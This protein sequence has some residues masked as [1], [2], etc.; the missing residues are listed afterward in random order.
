VAKRKPT[1][2]KALPAGLA[3]HSEIIQGIEVVDA[4]ERREHHTKDLVGMVA[5]AVGLLAVVALATYAQGTTAGITRDVIAMTS[6]VTAIFKATNNALMNAAT[7]LA[8]A[9]VLATLLF[10]RQFWPALQGSLAGIVSFGLAFLTA[11]GVRALDY[12]PMVTGLSAGP[13]G[14]YQVAIAPLAAAMAGILTAVGPRS[15]RPILRFSWNLLWLALAVWVLT[16][17]GTMGS[18]MVTVLLGRI[19][20][21]A[22]RYL[23]GVST[24]RA[25]GRGLI[26]GIR[27]A[28]IE[29]VRVVRVRDISDPE[30]PTDRL[31]VAAIRHGASTLEE[32]DDGAPAPPTTE[33]PEVGELS[34]VSDST[35]LALERQAGNRVYAVYT[36]EGRRWDALVLDGDQQVLGL[37]QRTW[38]A[39]RL[40]G[41]DQRSVVSLRQAA[42]RAALLSYTAASAGVRTPSLRGIGEASDSMMLLQS[43]PPGLRSIRDMRAREVQDQALVEM[44]R[45]LQLAH[46]AGLAHRSV[47]Q[48]C[49]LFG[50]GPDGQQVPWLTGWDNGDVASSELAR[51]LDRAQLATMLALRLGPDR[52]V[53][54]AAQVLDAESLA[55]VASLIQ[56]VALPSQTREEARGRAE[57]LDALRQELLD[58]SPGEPLER[59]P[60][61]VRLGWSKVVLL[62]LALV[63]VIVVLTTQ[64][65]TQMV[66]AVADTNPWWLVLAFGL[67]LATYVGAA[68]TL[69][70]FHRD[71]VS[72]WKA[73]LAQVAASFWAL[74]APGG[75]GP[76]AT[77]LRFLS[78][79]GS[80]ASLAI[81][82]V[83]LTQ[84]ALVFTTLL[85]LLG[86]GFTSG[87]TGVLS[88]LPGK[89]II[90]VVGALV[91]LASLLLIPRLRGW[92]WLK[93]GPTFAQVWPALTWVLSKPKRIILAMVGTVIQT[94]GYIA[95]F[96]AVLQAFDLGHL[97]LLNLALVFLLG[98]SAGSA[99]P[100]PGGVGGVEI[101]LAASLVAAGVGGATIAFSVALVF[102][103]I[104]YW[105]RVPLGWIAFRH[106]QHHGDL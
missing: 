51:A 20:G 22:A 4:P 25:A 99:V 41:M 18:A 16:G 1:R 17:G 60:S 31:N 38:R 90:F 72:L 88:N 48:D 103:L 57:T 24:D 71:N 89:A 43:H 7:L 58:L 94:G 98:N 67:A 50:L 10:R 54:A 96:W 11:W 56:P 64:N 85:M 21:Q 69:K 81:A 80:R 91:V 19:T 92:L 77:S 78:K 27:R 42:E 36:E 104:T 32:T 73:T 37:L 66:S 29:P 30:S 84:V 79:Q 62:T 106:L 55:Q 87:N 33:L 44:W 26:E 45:Q 95:A 74:V 35:A 100:T 70:G 2:S 52:T 63:A 102:R 47:T 59:P 83:A 23:G 6:A 68:M 34:A 93:I 61:L 49:V 75:I 46:S 13:A 8:P 97:S 5:S 53:Q 9:A 65:F 12:D 3:S 40:R 28:G 14:H 86:A 105:A 76:A 82:T 39:L 101:A 15:R